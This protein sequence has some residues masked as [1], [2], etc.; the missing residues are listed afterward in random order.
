M[1]KQFLLKILCIGCILAFI[2]GCAPT[3]TTDSGRVPVTYIS[4]AEDLT[5]LEQ[6]ELLF[7]Q[8]QLLDQ[9]GKE[10]LEVA[11]LFAKSG[12]LQRSTETR[13]LVNS[14]L[15][16]DQLFIEYTFLGVELNM[17]ADD[18]TAALS[19]IEDPRFLQLQSY[20]GRQYQHRLLSIRAD[21][22]TELGDSIASLRNTI[23]LATLLEN[24]SDISNVHN[25][26]W[27]QLARQPFNTLNQY[28]MDSD[29]ILAGWCELAANGRRYQNNKEAQ[30]VNFIGWKNNNKNHPAAIIPPSWFNQRQNNAGYSSQVAILLP[31]QGDYKGPSQTFLDGFMEA[32]YEL[33]QQNK[34]E[35]PNVRIHDT[36]LQTMEQAYGNAVAEGADIIIGGIRQSETEAL[37]KMSVLEVP[38]IT[39]NRIDSGDMVQNPNLFQFGNSQQDEIRQIAD[40]AWKKGYRRALFIAPENNWGQQAAVVFNSHW[41]NK[42]G[43]LVD[44][45]AYPDSVKDFTKFLKKP[46]QIDLSESR[47]IQLRRFVNSRVIY[48]PRRRQDIDF[49]VV[50]GYPERV[51]QIKPALDFLWAAD[52]PVYSS[53]EIYNGVSQS[54]LDRDLG[55]IQFTAMPWSLPGQLTS[56][57]NSDQTMHTA[58]R[59]LYARGHD[60]FLIHRNLSSLQNNSQVPLFGSTGILSISDGIIRRQVQWGEFQQGKVRNVQP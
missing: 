54:G 44:Q 6:T 21:I 43:V 59:Q 50:L 5:A 55:G 48:T 28:S 30:F 3:A 16:T 25:K 26:I 4:E 47:G 27:R 13:A 17:Q 10:M 38:T 58:Y 22:Y 56:E 46:L 52:L 14:D 11:I 36:S 15:L 12:S 32:Y 57:L 34:T 40:E 9:Q 1:S 23:A 20:L 29:P 18:P 31:L 19:N 24:K 53:S 7:A 60:S 33:Y 41:Q 39:L 45:V 37:T 35:P 49:V 51:R 2:G 8:A 42:N